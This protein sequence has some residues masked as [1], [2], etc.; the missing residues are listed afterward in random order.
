MADFIPAGQEWKVVMLM[1]ITP[2]SFDLGILPVLTSGWCLIL[3]LFL[4]VFCR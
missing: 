2:M 4:E 3:E 1:G